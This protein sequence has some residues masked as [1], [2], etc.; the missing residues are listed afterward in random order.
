MDEITMIRALRTDYAYPEEQRRATR[1]GLLAEMTGAPAGAPPA[2]PPRRARRRVPWQAGL[3]GVLAA[4]AAAV[5]AV[6]YLPGAAPGRVT[7]RAAAPPTAAQALELAAKT[8][9]SAAAPVPAGAR[10]LVWESRIDSTASAPDCRIGAGVAGEPYD[11][12][13]A[14][15][16]YSACPAQPPASIPRLRGAKPLPGF[17][18]LHWPRLPSQPGPLLAAIYRQLRAEPGDSLPGKAPGTVTAADL[19]EEVFGQLTDMLNSGLTSPSQAVQLAAMARIPGIK[20]VRGAHNLLGHPAIEI[21]VTGS[22]DRESVFLDPS[23]YALI[24]NT[25]FTDLPP[26]GPVTI[27]YAQVW[28]AYYDSNGNKL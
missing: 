3:G 23:S 12:T 17:S 5:V 20:I 19:N 16:G 2:A 18:A 8:A 26:T 25:Q 15:R 22:E 4:G 10:W 14:I 21:T 9:R 13:P 7:A 28:Q 27:T 1:A 11:P 24:G 6:A